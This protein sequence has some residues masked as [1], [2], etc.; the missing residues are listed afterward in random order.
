MRSPRPPL[1]PF[2]CVLAAK[3]VSA[4]QGLAL[5]LTL[6]LG[7]AGLEAQAPAPVAATMPAGE[8]DIESRLRQVQ[9]LDARAGYLT[10]STGSAL[11]TA[12][13]DSGGWLLIVPEVTTISNSAHPWGGNDGPMRAGKGSSLMTTLGLA[14]HRGGLTLMA[15]PQG[16]YEEN[17]ALPV[18][19]YADF[20]RPARNEWANPF[21]RGPEFID[22]PLRYGSGSRSAWTA[23]WR[24]SYEL[25]ANWRAGFG[26]ENRWWGPGVRNALLLSSNA[27]GFTQAFVETHEPIRTRFGELDVSWLLGRLDESEFFDDNPDNDARSL[28]AAAVNWR[29]PA[30]LSRLVPEVGIARAVMTVDAPTPNALFDVFRNVGR[31]YSDSTDRRAG[32][33]QILTLWG[34]W[35]VPERGFEAWVEWARYEQAIN[36]RDLLVNPG[37]AQGY[38]VGFSVARPL[39]GGTLLLQSEFSYAEPSPSIRVR[40]VVPSY[41]SAGVPQGWTHDGQMLGPAM[42]PGGSTQWGQLDWRGSRWRFGGELGRLR[43]DNG[44]TFVQPTD[45]A[46]REDVSYWLTLRLGRRIGPWNAVLEFT[47]AARLNYLYQAYD[48]PPEEGGWTGVDLQNR[49]LRLVLSPVARGRGRR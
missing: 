18:F 13:P 15:M 33:D 32:L 31:P 49:T 6:A 42:G 5:A 9:G 47:D 41:T 35:L 24:A 21:H 20:W 1:L 36:L 27:P 7:G 46:R 37:H 22:L 43:R 16:V 2:D 40:P 3:P 8:A 39:R 19:P 26:S 28:N 34:R 45:F 23:Q 25:S 29:P 14:W 38:T 12:F 10:R 17:A 30:Q 44:V 4:A 11:D 48:L